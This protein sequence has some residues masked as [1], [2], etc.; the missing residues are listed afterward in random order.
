MANDTKPNILL[1]ISDEHKQDCFGAYGNKDIKTPHLDKLAS[2]GTKF[3]NCFATFPVCT[4][5]RYSLLT[6]LYV[7]QHLGWTNRSTLPH[8]L[9]TFPRLLKTIGYETACVGKMHFTPTY[10]D[11]GFDTMILAEQDG[12][13]RYDDDYHRYLKN[14][15]LI[16]YI[17]LRDQ[18]GEYRQQAPEDYY[19]NF[20]TEPSHLKEEDYSTTWIGRQACKLLKNWGKGENFLEVGFIK[21]HHPHDAPAPWCNMYNPEDL[22]LPSGW[23]DE[24]SPRDIKF[25][26]GFF[27][28]KKLDETTMKKV[29]A[30]YY[31]S[32]S[33]IDHQV[34]EMIKILKKKGIYDNTLII[35]TSDHGDYMGHHHLILKSN[36]MYDPVI[37]VPLIVKFPQHSNNN[38]TNEELVSLVDVTA[39]ILDITMAPI[40]MHLWGII[41]PLDEDHH[42]E[43]I[44]AEDNNGNYMI[45]TKTKKLLLCGNKESQFFDLTKDP[46]ELNNLYKQKEKQEEIQELKEELFN[47]L[48]FESRPPVHVD[49]YGPVLEADNVPNLH[50]DHREEM[51]QY[52]KEK[53]NEEINK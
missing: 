10:S 29:L 16:D 43:F 17:D 50:D 13:G 23:I 33:Q 48:I 5:S 4:P 31:A 52:F 38:K 40:P 39:T 27:D 3:T 32:I 20:G 34:G 7:H 35:Y 18:V 26:K 51:R 36:Y 19:A 15:G 24:C 46:H 45:R 47:F 11:L 6:G 30:Q 41:Q 22:D 44:F 9:D 14:K 2:D 37:K 21:P 1:I 49:K 8:G 53:F 12:P 28:F 25:N 42:R